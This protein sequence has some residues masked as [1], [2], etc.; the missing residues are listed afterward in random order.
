MLAL[1]SIAGLLVMVGVFVTG[2]AV[3]YRV[4]AVGWAETL[5]GADEYDGLL[6]GENVGTEVLTWAFFCCKHCTKICC[7]FFDRKF[8]TP[9]L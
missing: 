1:K 7:C 3:R 2:A 5:G 4:V 6:D 8:V 9:S